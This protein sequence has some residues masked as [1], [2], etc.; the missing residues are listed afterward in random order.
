MLCLIRRIYLSYDL[1]QCIANKYAVASVRVLSRFHNPYVLWYLDPE[2]FLDV[3]YIG[4]VLLFI[5]ISALVFGP[6]ALLLSLFLDVFLFFA[7]KLL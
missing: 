2:L 6:V 3:I 5:F 7:L 1:F 4:K